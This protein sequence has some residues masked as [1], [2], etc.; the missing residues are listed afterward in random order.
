MPRLHVIDELFD[1]Y[2]NVN[3]KTSAQLDIIV[4]DRFVPDDTRA[5]RPSLVSSP[6]PV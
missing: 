6:R 5:G 1:A 3:T 4:V 2:N